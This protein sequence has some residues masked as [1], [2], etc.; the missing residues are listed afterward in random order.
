MTTIC[1]SCDYVG[2]D[3]KFGDG[4]CPE[5]F[6]QQPDD[7]T[8]GAIQ[9]PEEKDEPDKKPCP[10]C[11]K[12]LTWVKDGSRPRAHKCVEKEEPKPEQPKES[13]GKIT[14]DMVIDAYV[15]TRDQIAEEKK[16]FDEKVADLNMLQDKRSAWLL[17]KMDALG[18]DSFKTGHGTCFTDHKDS[19]TVADREEFFSWVHGDWENRNHFLEK[20]VAK[21]AVKA[22]LDDG[23]TPPPGVN[24]VKVRDIKVRRA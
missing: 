6:A 2:Q 1:T 8:T 5:C 13:G 21:G 10:D 7:L 12:V 22:M 19:A 11:G 15:K 14:V 17:G 20:R 16:K 4:I 18:V 9:P 24:Y 23:E 3:E